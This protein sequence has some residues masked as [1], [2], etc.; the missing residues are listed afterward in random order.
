M[1]DDDD[2]NNILD[3]AHLY[4]MGAFDDEPIDEVQENA[5]KEQPHDKI[6][7]VLVDAQK[8]SETMKESNKF[9]KVLDDHKK[10]LYPDCKHGHKKLGSTLELLQWKAANGVTDKSFEDLLG[11][12]KNMLPEGNELPST[13]YEA[14]KFV[15]PLGLEV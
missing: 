13:T 4:E 3:L 5:A 12:I 6:G 8:H 2:D 7:Q 15:C 14:T 10:L 1:E 11:I 9:E